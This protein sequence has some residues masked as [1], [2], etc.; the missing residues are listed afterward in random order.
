MIDCFYSKDP[1]QGEI[2]S[3]QKAPVKERGRRAK[4]ATW[5]R[6]RGLLLQC[7]E[8]VV[9]GIKMLNGVGQHLESGQIPAK[10]MPANNKTMLRGDNC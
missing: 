7:S 4:W 10:E 6:G 3:K 8:G 1:R 2:K 5:S 9:L